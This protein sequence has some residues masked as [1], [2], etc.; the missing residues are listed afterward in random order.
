MWRVRILP[1]FLELSLLLGALTP[2]PQPARWPGTAHKLGFVLITCYHKHKCL[3]ELELCSWSLLLDWQVDHISLPQTQ[4]SKCH[5]LTLVE[6]T[7]GWLETYAMPHATSQNTNLCLG[8]QD[9]CLH[10]TPETIE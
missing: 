4:H 10:G 9:L 5:M 8:K 3:S 6:A 7:T 1:T 2:C